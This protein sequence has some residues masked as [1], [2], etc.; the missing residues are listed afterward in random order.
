M[1]DLKTAIITGGT[2]DIGAATAKLLA[3]QGWHVGLLDVDADRLARVSGSIPNTTGHVC[4]VTDEH[5]VKGALDAFGHVPDLVVNNAGAGRFGPLLDMALEDFK[6]VL[7]VNLVGAF[8]VARTAA[9]AM[10]KRGSGTVINITSIN[11]ITAGPGSGAYPASKS[12]LAKLTEQMAQEW[13]PLGL[14]VNAIAP[15]FIDAGLSTPFFKDKDIRSQRENAVPIRRLGLAEDIA[16][17]VAFLASDSASYV[18]GH[19]LVVDGGVAMSLLS[20]LPRSKGD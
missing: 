9:Q 3:D 12:G 17:A 19:Q 15:G 6:L 18:S 4:D 1:A 20:Q 7:D 10:A 8:L 11:S 14:R 13:G 2:G 5:A 16:N